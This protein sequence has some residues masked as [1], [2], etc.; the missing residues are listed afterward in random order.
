MRSRNLLAIRRLS[1][2]RRRA[3]PRMTTGTAIE[4]RP[5]PDCV[6]KVNRRSLCLYKIVTPAPL[7]HEEQT[8]DLLKLSALWRAQQR[9]EIN[10]SDRGVVAHLQWPPSRSRH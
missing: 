5:H 1:P 10:G 9:M 3:R 4:L 2:R 6:A 7:H 8:R